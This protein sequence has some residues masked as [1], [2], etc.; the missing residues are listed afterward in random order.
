[1]K[2]DELERAGKIEKAAELVVHKIGDKQLCDCT[3]AELELFQACRIAL[4]PVSTF[5]F[6]ELELQSYDSVIE[7]REKEAQSR[8][9]RNKREA[10]EPE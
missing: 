6:A 2:Q 4:R 5:D 1:M 7:K 9:N 8:E 10:G 3:A